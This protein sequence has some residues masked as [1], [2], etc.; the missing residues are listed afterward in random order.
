KLLHHRAIDQVSPP[1]SR[2]L[3]RPDQAAFHPLVGKEIGIAAHPGQRITE[4]LFRLLRGNIGLGRNVSRR[5]HRPPPVGT[6][7]WSFSGSI[8][9]RAHTEHRGSGRAQFGGFF[10]PTLPTQ[11]ETCPIDLTSIGKHSPTWNPPEGDVSRETSP[12]GTEM[13]GGVS[14]E[15]PPPDKAMKVY[16]G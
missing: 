15:T 2:H 7:P 3:T 8:S 5:S 13:G 11:L 4:H 16:S 9:L 10:V 6:R 14:R 1:E 12:S